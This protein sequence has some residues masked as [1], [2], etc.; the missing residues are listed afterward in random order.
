MARLIDQDRIIKLIEKAK[1]AILK[2]MEVL[3]ELKV[4]GTEDY[5][6]GVEVTCDDII[7]EIK[8]MKDEDSVDTVQVVRCKDCEHFSAFKKPVE[9]FD[10]RCGI[11][12]G[13]YGEVDEDFFCQY[14]ERKDGEK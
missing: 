4:K 1:I 7:R 2:Q 6:K 9:D 13:I 3:K 12:I 11:N 5:A 8:N 10:G 14:G